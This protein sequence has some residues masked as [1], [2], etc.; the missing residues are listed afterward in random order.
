MPKRITKSRNPVAKAAVKYLERQGA[1]QKRSAKIL[2][3]HAGADDDFLDLRDRAH[4]LHEAS[5]ELV[6]KSPALAIIRKVQA[7]RPLTKAER[8]YEIT[9]VAELRGTLL[10]TLEWQYGQK[11]DY[12]VVKRAAESLDQ[13]INRC[14]DLLFKEK[15]SLA[16]LPSDFDWCENNSVELISNEKGHD[17]FYPRLLDD[18]QN[19]KQ[20][21]HI[22]MYGIKGQIGQETDI[23][24]QVAKILAAKAAA[25][26]EV[27]LILDAL[28][29]GLSF[30]RR[31]EPAAA[32]LEWMKQH[33]INIVINHP[34][35]PFDLQRFLRLDHRKLYVI[36]GQ[37]GYCGGMG[38]ENHF[39][40]WFDVMVRMEGDVV[41]QLQIHFLSTFHWQGG[42]VE[43]PKQQIKLEDQLRQHYFPRVNHK[44]GNLKAKLL[45]NIP[46]PGRRTITEA[47][48]NALEGTAENFYFMNSYFN[49]DWLAAKLQQLAERLYKQGRIWHPGISVPSGVL[50]MLHRGI[51]GSTALKRYGIDEKLTG[52]KRAGIGL[53]LYPEL[54]HAKVYVQDCRLS[55]IGSLNIDDA[56]LERQWETNVLIEGKEFAD[57]VTDLFRASER[58]SDVKVESE[59][60][61][62]FVD[63]TKQ[64]IAD[65]LEFVI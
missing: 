55:N 17:R 21:I 12:Y 48:V 64:K 36:D 46:A 59:L 3:L 18:L 35:R 53:L 49:T 2:E 65:A 27:N 45:P 15:S 19:A 37:I 33:R 50:A 28:G 10:P 61:V 8:E 11:Q 9:N 51:S 4:I 25:G 14:I 30:A 58:R 32:F 41:N 6:A 20:H 62:S 16:D 60:Q 57:R 29:C 24:W 13:Q 38:I 40:D 5:Q 1:I 34:L 39:R 54:L 43:M 23:A 63:W 52:L 31:F 47:Y 42:R 56:S 26:V 7:G 44:A 22:A